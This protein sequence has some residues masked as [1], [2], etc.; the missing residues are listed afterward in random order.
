MAVKKYTELDFDQIKQ[1]LKDFLKGQPEFQDYNFEG[2]GINLLLD[3]LAYNTGYNAFYANMIANEMFLDTAVIRNNVISRAKALGYNPTTIRMPY[4]KLKIDVQLPVGFSNP[5]PEYIIVPRFHEFTSNI[6]LSGQIKLYTLQRYVLPRTFAD[7]SVWRYSGEADIYQGQ[8]LT[9]TFFVDDEVNPGQ[10]YLLPN[11]NIDGTHIFVEI[12][13][14]ASSA[15]YETWTRGD[16]ITTISATDKVFFVQEA[17]NQY[18]EIYFGDGFIGRKLENGNEIRVNYFVTDG[19]TYHGV[20]KFAV[21]SLYAP[22]DGNVGSIAPQNITLTTLSNLSNG[23]AGETIDQIKYRAPLYYDTQARAV[24]KNDYE[25]LLVKDY[26]QIEHVRVWG[27]EQ[28]V[29]PKYGV[30]FVSAK[31]KGALAFNTIEKESIINSIIRPRNM[32][33]IEVEMVDPEYINITL[34]VKVRY[35]SRVNNKSSGEIESLVRKAIDQYAA[36]K[37]SGFD[38]NFR[39][40]TLLRY[41]DNADSSIVGSNVNVGLKYT[42]TPPFNV[43][44]SYNFSFQSKLDLGDVLHEVRTIKSSSFI[45]NGF[46]TLIAD[47]GL[48]NLF[49]FRNFGANRIIVQ[50]SVGTINYETGDIA[51]PS[52]TIQGI[53]NGSTK[54]YFYAIAA[55]DDFFAS[56]N[57]MLAIDQ[58]DVRVNVINENR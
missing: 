51:I 34:D 37:L 50:Q 56:R 33:S 21:N 4:A 36:D 23:A 3:V 45:F 7:G 48:G 44:Q 19:T 6:T 57:R 39:Y 55:E 47:D 32:V 18:L 35:E 49:S 2:S 14:S 38:T 16:D 52:L 24:T 12:K 30:V 29:P 5:M 15:T 17:E 25:T 20:K 42:L 40:S 9:H 26:P 31:P 13:P 41:I 1:N 58:I 10:R 46:E 28:N 54:L 8:R 53:P 43:S 27:G 11:A 22:S